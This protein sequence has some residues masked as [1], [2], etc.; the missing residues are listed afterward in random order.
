MKN[1]TKTAPKVTVTI[2]E[3]DAGFLLAAL[4]KAMEWESDVAYYK[5]YSKLST[6]IEKA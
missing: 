5:K 1:T 2:S 3:E 4:D 6:L